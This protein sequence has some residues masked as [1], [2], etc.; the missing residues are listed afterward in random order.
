MIDISNLKRSVNFGALGIAAGL[1]MATS[2]HA[3][4]FAP[5]PPAFAPAVNWGGVYL[6]GHIGG[7]QAKFGGVFNHIDGSVFDTSSAVF[8]EDLFTSGVLGGIQAGFNWDVGSFVLGIEGDVSFMD[9]HGHARAAESSEE[10]TTNVDMLASIRGRIGMPVGAERRGMFYA[11]GGVAFADLDTTIF[12][13]GR[14]DVDAEPWERQNVNFNDIGA[15][16][17]GGF[18]WAATD[19][20][21]LRIESLYYFF[22]DSKTIYVPLEEGEPDL[23][24]PGKLK[25]KDIWVARVGVDYHFSF[26]GM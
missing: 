15:V 20:L 7:G 21:R 12:W 24:R 23:D 14:G 11:T 5:P 26:P 13:E 18:Q 6:G 10:V 19:A 25:F 9:W 3:A 8:G 4:D 1:L 17:G 22:N 2:A 16:V